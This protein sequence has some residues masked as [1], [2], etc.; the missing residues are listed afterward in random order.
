[1]DDEAHRRPDFRQM[2]EAVLRLVP[3]GREICEFPVID[4]DQQIVI[5]LV[6]LP[7][8][9]L[10]DPCSSA[11]GPEEDDLQNAATLLEV[12]RSLLEGVL[13]FLVQDLDDAREL[14]LFSLR[15]M[16][17]AGLHRFGRVLWN[18]DA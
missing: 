10:I 6:S 14:A 17:E 4:D 9:R 11:V 12:G 16:I 2:H 15:K 7:R 5:R 3:V 18:H 13:E 1:M 8:V